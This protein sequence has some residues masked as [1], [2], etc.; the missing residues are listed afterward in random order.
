MKKR[1]GISFAKN[2]ARSTYKV[3]N[4][5]VFKTKLHREIF[6][7]K[8]KKLSSTFPYSVFFKMYTLKN[9][10]GKIRFE[11]QSSLLKKEIASLLSL[12]ASELLC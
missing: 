5:V 7:F 10:V 2:I 6:Q 3:Q 11:I 4:S 1:Y 9:V 12:V 8:K